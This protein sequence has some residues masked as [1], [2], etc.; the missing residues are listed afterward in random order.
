MISRAKGL[1]GILDQRDAVPLTRFHERLKIRGL[2]V[3][4]D[5][6]Q[7]LWH[8]AGCRLTA[9]CVLDQLRIEVPGPLLAVDED[10]PSADVEDGVDA[11]GKRQGAH[12]YFVTR[13]DA[14]KAQR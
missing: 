10:R 2:S 14:G 12:E 13:A 3:E 9:Q 1:R 8:L 4:V 6:H 7:S 11:C 5:D